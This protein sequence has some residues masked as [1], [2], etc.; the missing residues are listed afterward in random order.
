MLMWSKK[1]LVELMQIIIGREGERIHI[2]IVDGSYNKCTEGGINMAARELRWE[3][4]K[5]QDVFRIQ[6][7]LNKDGFLGVKATPMGGTWFV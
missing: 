2:E 1:G 5:Q 3:V 7:K 6:E 4:I